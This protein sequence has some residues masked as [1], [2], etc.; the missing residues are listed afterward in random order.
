L[1]HTADPQPHAAPSLHD[2]LL[3]VASETPTS[4]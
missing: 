3:G 4:A 1:G 2:T